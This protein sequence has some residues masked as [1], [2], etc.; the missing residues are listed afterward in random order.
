MKMSG[1]LIKG[2]KTIKKSMVYNEDE[3]LPYRDA[4]EQ[5]LIKLC[6]E[7]D[8]E[9]PVWLRKNTSEFAAF[10][11][12]SFNREHFLEDIKFDRFEMEVTS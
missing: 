8:I 7:L 12:T 5:C 1:R 4:L 3:N 11:K 10:Q 2:N 6:R 9:V